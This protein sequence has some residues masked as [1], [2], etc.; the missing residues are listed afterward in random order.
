MNRANRA[1]RCAVRALV[2][3]ASLMAWLVGMG[4]APGRG[5]W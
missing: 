4:V 5:W 3:Y 2:V 1:V